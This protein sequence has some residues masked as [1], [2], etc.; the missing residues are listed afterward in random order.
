MFFKNYAIR[1]LL[2]YSP[3]IKYTSYA[4]FFIFFYSLTDISV[5]N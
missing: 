1:F 3:S 5:Y 4:P 2:I